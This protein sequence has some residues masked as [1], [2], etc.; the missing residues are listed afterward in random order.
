MEGRLNIKIRSGKKIFH[1]LRSKRGREAPKLP[2][3]SGCERD[4]DRHRSRRRRMDLQPHGGGGD[5]EEAGGC[6]AMIADG[7]RKGNLDPISIS[8]FYSNCYI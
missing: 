1:V 6:A 7:D 4:S 5:A 3:P 2:P 8:Y